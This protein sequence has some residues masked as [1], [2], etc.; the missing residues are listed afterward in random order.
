MTS[1]CICSLHFVPAST[2]RCQFYPNRA[3]TG[4]TLETRVNL[5]QGE[6]LPQIRTRPVIILARG[7]I[8]GKFWACNMCVV[9]EA[10][11]ARRSC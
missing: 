5:D 8:P 3:R 2:K 11:Q 1:V 7:H 6:R 10:A 4:N 9:S